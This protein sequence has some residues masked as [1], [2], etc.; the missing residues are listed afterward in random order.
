MSDRRKSLD[1]T[2]EQEFEKVVIYIKDEFIKKEV[3]EHIRKRIIEDI[4]QALRYSFVRGAQ[5]GSKWGINELC[6]ALEKKE[7]ET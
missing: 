1:E 3:P 7:D 5:T 4:S 2:I 6:I